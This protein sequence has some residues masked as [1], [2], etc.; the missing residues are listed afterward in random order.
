[1][2]ARV[3]YDLSDGTARIFLDTPQQGVSPGQA[4]VFHT[5]GEGARV[6]G[7]GWITAT[8]NRKDAVAG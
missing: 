1:M 2:P 4:A 3:R 8:D 5:A 7:G 6:L